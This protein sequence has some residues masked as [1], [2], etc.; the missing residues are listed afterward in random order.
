MVIKLKTGVSFRVPDAH[1]AQASAAAVNG[2]AAMGVPQAWRTVAERGAA[3]VNAAMAE[4][5]QRQRVTAERK[6]AVA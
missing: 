6:E 3:G 4:L 2:I 5:G 1:L